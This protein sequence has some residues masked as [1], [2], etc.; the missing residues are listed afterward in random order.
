MNEVYIIEFAG[1]INIE[2]ITANVS[3]QQDK[4]WVVSHN[5]TRSCYPDDL[6]KSMCSSSTNNHIMQFEDG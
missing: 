2:D 6:K 1:E 3:Q 4:N 5:L